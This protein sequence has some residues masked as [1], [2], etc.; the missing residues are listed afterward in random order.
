M[1]PFTDLEHRN[2]AKKK[3]SDINVMIPKYDTQIKGRRES[4]SHFA[5][6]SDL[7]C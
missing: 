4:I 6:Y 2:I 3:K 5:G 1:A 7:W